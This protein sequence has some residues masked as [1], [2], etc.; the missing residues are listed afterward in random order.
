[1]NETKKTILIVE[2]EPA[3]QRPLSEKLD[4]EGFIVLGAKNGEEGLVI[5]LEKHPDLILLD[6]LMPKIDGITMIKKL[7]QESGWGK[8]VPVILLTNLNPKDEKINQMITECEPAYYIM[9]SN[10]TLE[11]LVGKIRERLSRQY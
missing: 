1:M 7:R 6:V 11:N 4:H 5:A 10:S 9:K 3:Y 8:I 2:D